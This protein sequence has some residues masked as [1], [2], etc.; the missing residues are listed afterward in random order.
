MSSGLLGRVKSRYSG[1]TLSAR[2]DPWRFLKVPRSP[3]DGTF[4]L[5][6]A[7]C[8]VRRGLPKTAAI[9]L[10]RVNVSVADIF[11]KAILE[12]TKDGADTYA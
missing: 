12:G 7:S 5:R 3:Y 10:L 4:S 9:Q 11:R 1:D 2:I 6:E 8:R